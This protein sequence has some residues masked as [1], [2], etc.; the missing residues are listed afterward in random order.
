MEVGLLRVSVS[1]GW[2]GSEDAEAGSTGKADGW[3]WLAAV[4]SIGFPGLKIQTRGTQLYWVRPGPPAAG[5][6]SVG[7]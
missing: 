6:V 3:G 1:A 2:L 5:K 4:L 7:D